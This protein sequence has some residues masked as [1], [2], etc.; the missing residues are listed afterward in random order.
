[1]NGKMLERSVRIPGRQP[2][3]DDFRSKMSSFFLLEPG[4]GPCLF[5]RSA[6]TCWKV[7]CRVSSK[8]KNKYVRSSD[9]FFSEGYFLRSVTKRN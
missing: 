8:K 1:M 3:S 6:R 2:P 5:S 9:L 4:E 7:E